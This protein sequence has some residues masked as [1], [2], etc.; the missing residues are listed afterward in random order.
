MSRRA[1]KRRLRKD[2]EILWEGRP[3]Q[4]LLPNRPMEWLVFPVMFLLI[5]G[6]VLLGSIGLF[7]TPKTGLDAAFHIGLLAI[8]AVIV[9]V[10]AALIMLQRRRTYYAVTSQRAFIR[11]SGGNGLWRYSRF[12]EIGPQT[13]IRAR[14]GRKRSNILIAQRRPGLQF[15][16]RKAGDRYFQFW[17]I[18]DGE[19]VLDLLK[20]VQA[21]ET[22]D[23]QPAPGT[24]PERI[25]PTATPTPTAE[26]DIVPSFLR[27]ASAAVDTLSEKR[28][29]AA[30][31]ARPL[32][33][34]RD[35]PPLTPEEDAKDPS[36]ARDD[37]DNTSR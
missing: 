28:G 30:P 19:E 24:P 11:Y 9:A 35:E 21:G 25:E 13:H 3:R 14:I 12:E 17:A 23:A 27:T 31:E 8:P 1:L 22:P 5:P 15:A 10:M 16:K 6:F 34:D 7:L 2:E 33:D 20:Q 18:A 36:D 26:D 29:P 32:D 37:T 4:G